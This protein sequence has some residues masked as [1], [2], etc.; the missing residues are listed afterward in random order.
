MINLIIISVFIFYVVSSL[1][2]RITIRWMYEN[3]WTNINPDISDLFVIYMPFLNTLGVIMIFVID[4]LPS[5]F[6]NCDTDWISKHIGI[7]R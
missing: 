7:D 5:K 4:I 2:A 6:K 1:L 3:K